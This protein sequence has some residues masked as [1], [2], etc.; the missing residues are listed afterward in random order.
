VTN[1]DDVRKQVDE[2]EAWFAKAMDLA[3]SADVTH[4][5]RPGGHI[6]L[7]AGSRAR[8]DLWPELGAWLAERSGR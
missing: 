7:V 3:S 6:G 4:L 8:N 1:N 2:V 5:D